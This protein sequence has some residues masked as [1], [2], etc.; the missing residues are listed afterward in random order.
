MEKI[1]NNTVDDTKKE[2][3]EHKDKDRINLNSVEYH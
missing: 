3:D 1:I 2:T